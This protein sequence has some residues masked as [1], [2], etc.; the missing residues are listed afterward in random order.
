MI[1]KT[2]IQK[3]IHPLK[4]IPTST[5]P[6][7]NLHHDIEGILFDIYGTLF[8]SGSGDISLAGQHSPRMEKIKIL[9]AKHA[10]HF[11]AREL[12]DRLHET[13]K[14]RHEELRNRGVDFPEVKI[15]RIWQQVLP[16]ESQVNVKQFAAEFE[17]ISGI[18]P[19]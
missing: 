9:L 17:M 18:K 1:Y 16:A 15:D 19:T 7:G 6:A 13:I 8:I 4:P 14:A 11:T 3:Y 2:S 12:L 5:S 10:L